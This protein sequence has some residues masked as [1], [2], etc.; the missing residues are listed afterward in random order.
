MNPS[1]A[2][3]PQGLAGLL[4]HPQIMAAGD[5]VARANVQALDEMDPETRWLTADMGR[6]ALCGSLLMLDALGS[7]TGVGLMMS[8][9]AYNLCSR[10]RVLSFLHYAQAR[11]RI[12]IPSGHEPWTQRRL[13][14]SA[15]FEAPFRRIAQLRI[16]GMSLL[17][18][19][20]AA[21]ADRMDDPAAHRA[22]LAAT[23]MMVASAPE[24]FAGPPTAMTLFMQRDGGMDILRDLTAS[25]PAE[26]PRYLT[27]APLSRLA[28][29]RRC[30]VSRTQV[31]RVLEEAEAAGLLTA[32]K[33]QVSFSQA[34]SDDALHHLAFTTRTMQ[35][36]CAAAGL[37]A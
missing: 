25:Q 31:A 23:G 20:L 33:D 37:L 11:G 1:E 5:A 3:S 28:L 4:A 15:G 19:E 35:L 7:A 30:H 13:S 14:V 8:A 2:L 34:L 16:R 6:A 32:S 17:A 24:I 9:A 26:R 21:A 12:T 22:L 18:P 27:A 29:A 36:A 10:G